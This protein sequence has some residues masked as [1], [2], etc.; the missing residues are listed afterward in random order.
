M[1]GAVFLGHLEVLMWSKRVLMIITGNRFNIFA[2]VSLIDFSY[3]FLTFK[4]VQRPLTT[5]L[6]VALIVSSTNCKNADTIVLKL[7][8]FFSR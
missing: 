6:P 5:L 4:N 2:K 7:V 1:F 3:T 8:L